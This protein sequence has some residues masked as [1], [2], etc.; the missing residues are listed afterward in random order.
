[1]LAA[2][3]ILGGSVQIRCGSRSP[4]SGSQPAVEN[5]AHRSSGASVGLSEILALGREEHI[6]LSQGPE[7]RVLVRQRKR[8]TLSERSGSQDISIL[9]ECTSNM[10][11]GSH[12]TLYVLCY[13]DC[14]RTD[15]LEILQV[16]AYRQV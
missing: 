1:M 3:Q 10:P 11:G 6:A 2:L 15:G 4:D 12:H 16:G 5:L 7:V 14:V 9:R 13:F 8:E